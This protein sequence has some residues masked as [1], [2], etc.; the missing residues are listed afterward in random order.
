MKGGMRVKKLFFGDQWH[1][2]DEVEVWTKRRTR[3]EKWRRG[4]KGERTV[5]WGCKRIKA[6]AYDC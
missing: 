2:K 6:K 5:G 1:L 4:W 3:K